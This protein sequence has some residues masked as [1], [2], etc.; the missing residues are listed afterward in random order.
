MS[1]PLEQV[2]QLARLSRLELSEEALTAMASQLS[3][4]LEH[5]DVVLSVPAHGDAPAPV[6][7]SPRL[8]ADTAAFRD[9]TPAGLLAA[10]EAEEGCFRVP[11]VLSEG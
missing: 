4:V 6:L 5:M 7:P 3:R 9:E 8:R 2:R 10:P 11:R 1:I